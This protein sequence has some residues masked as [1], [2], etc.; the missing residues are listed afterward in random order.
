MMPTFK[1]RVCTYLLAGLEYRDFKPPLGLFQWTKANKEDT[2][3]LIHT[4]NKHLD[5]TPV[6]D[7]SLDTVFAKMWDDLEQKLSALPAPPGTLPPPRSTDEMI[8][9]IL[10]LS[11]ATAQ[12]RKSVEALDPY[13][14]AFAEFLPV[15]TQF[16]P[17]LTEAMKA[18]QKPMG[19][20]PTY[21]PN[22]PQVRATQK[23]Y[24]VKL[25][26]DGAIKRIEGAT[27]VPDPVGRLV[28][29]D[30]TG[31]II[32]RFADV[33]SWWPETLEETD[34]NKPVPAPKEPWL[35]RQ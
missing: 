29:L 27:A 13:L 14:P 20:P 34:K 32:A 30:D 18:A 28:I 25:R 21:P 35:P 9:E 7:L 31:A 19:L 3:K 4:I 17:L 8:V 10:E 5:V 15:L 26:D 33:E 6:P 11:R 12:S 24:I 22:F 16:M 1:T 23:V 2:R